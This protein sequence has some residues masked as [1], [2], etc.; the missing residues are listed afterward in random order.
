MSVGD[1]VLVDVDAD[2]F[3][4]ALAAGDSEEAGTTVGVY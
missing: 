4:E 1:A 3:F 2:Y